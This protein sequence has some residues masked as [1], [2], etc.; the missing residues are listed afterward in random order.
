M[1]QDHAV[2]AAAIQKVTELTDASP[3]SGHS[4]L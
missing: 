4:L 1:K 3:E 2:L